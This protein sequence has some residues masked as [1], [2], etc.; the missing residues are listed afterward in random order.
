MTSK[1]AIYETLARS[2]RSF[3]QDLWISATADM[4]SAPQERSDM[5]KVMRR[6]WC[7]TARAIRQAR[8][9]ESELPC[10][11]RKIL[12]M[13][14]IRN[15]DSFTKKTFRTFKTSS[16]CTTTCARNHLSRW[17]L[18]ANV[19]QRANENGDHSCHS[20]KNERR[21]RKNMPFQHEPSA[22]QL[23]REPAH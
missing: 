2:W 13:Y 12:I 4:N 14:Q 16:K 3:C 23:L 21:A 20:S 11:P 17:P 7:A 6:L 9:D 8:S 15:D 19:L 18:P 1:D 22:T 10:L 5:Q